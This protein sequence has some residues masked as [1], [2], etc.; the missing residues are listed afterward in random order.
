[1]GEVDRGRGHVLVPTDPTRGDL[2]GD[3]VAVVASL[4][5]HVRGEGTRGDRADDDPLG[6]QPH[7]HPLG[8]VDDAGLARVV[9]VRLQGVEGEPVDGADVDDLG[10]VA[11]AP[12]A[13]TEQVLGLPGEEEGRLDVEVHDLVPAVLGELVEGRTPG[14]AGVVDEDVEV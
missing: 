12:V 6:G 10:L 3:L 11:A 1:G 4:L 9:R 2:P 7:G 8:E 14:R 13:G 5:V